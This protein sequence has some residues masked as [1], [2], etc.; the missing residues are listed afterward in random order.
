MKSQQHQNQQPRLYTG[1]VLSWALWQS[2]PAVSTP[3]TPKSGLPYTYSV[4]WCLTEK[5]SP[6]PVICSPAAVTV[7]GFAVSTK[8]QYKWNIVALLTPTILTGGSWIFFFAVSLLV[9]SWTLHHV[10]MK[11]EILQAEDDRYFCYQFQYA[12]LKRQIHW[13][14]KNY[15]KCKM[16]NTKF[17]IISLSTCQVHFFGGKFQIFAVFSG[18]HVYTVLSN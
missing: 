2:S 18:L 10:F 17:L 7:E 11:G 4:L 8:A 12:S 14:I 1:G 9:F 5:P 3:L 13:H 16:V 15:K 6:A